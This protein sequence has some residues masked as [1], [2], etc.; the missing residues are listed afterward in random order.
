MMLEKRSKMNK[1]LAHSPHIPVSWGELFDK[2][3]I[4]E[5]KMG[6]IKS[7]SAL[8]NISKELMLLQY[9]AKSNIEINNDLKTLLQDLKST[10]EA[11]WAIEDEIR[12]KEK[13][14]TFDDSFIQLARTVYITNDKRSSIKKKINSYLKSELI[15]EKSYVEYQK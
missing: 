7:A 14:Q 15:E 1:E 4:L 5:I 10:N 3:S 11:L 12:V 8:R 6:N 2:I 9:I 13:E